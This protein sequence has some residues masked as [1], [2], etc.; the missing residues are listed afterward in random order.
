MKQ[1]MS[2][3]QV[4]ND[5][6]T[7]KITKI[8]NCSPKKPEWY[9]IN[10]Q[11]NTKILKV[12]FRHYFYIVLPLNE[13]VDRICIL[14]NRQVEYVIGPMHWCYDCFDYERYLGKYYIDKQGYIEWKNKKR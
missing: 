14:C 11:D 1:Y 10:K 12:Y 2:L 7:C 4:K 5:F 9:I 6:P 8:R 13:D 3:N